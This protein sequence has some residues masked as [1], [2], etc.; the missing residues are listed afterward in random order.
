MAAARPRR[1]IF[2]ALVSHALACTSASTMRLG[3]MPRHATDEARHAADEARRMATVE[4]KRAA[5]EARRAADEARRMATVEAKRAAD[6]ARRITRS[7]QVTTQTTLLQLQT[8]HVSSVHWWELQAREF[9]AGVDSQLHH[10]WGTL[11]DR[12]T[13]PLPAARRLMQRVRSKAT[14]SLT[15]ASLLA[16]E[17]FGQL[18]SFITTELE[19]RLRPR[20]LPSRFPL[21][22]FVVRPIRRALA[23]RRASNLV[24][25]DDV[26]DLSGT[27]RLEERIRM[28]DFLKEMGFSALQRAVVLKAGQVQVIAMRG[29]EL[30]VLTRDVRGT[31]ELVSAPLPP[32]LAAAAAAAAGRLAPPSTVHS[33]GA[34]LRRVVSAVGGAARACLCALGCPMCP[35]RAPPLPNLCRAHCRCCRSATPTAS[36]TR[37]A[38]ATCRSAAPPSSRAATS[39]SPSARRAAATPSPSAAAPCSPTGG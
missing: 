18:P 14:R 10:A 7:I 6:E 27:W 26:A 11:H 31:S 17:P 5:D 15:S 21:Q 12:A 19:R 36:S 25:S 9:A 1:L 29:A 16:R 34:E 39:S 37:T 4:A 24:Q 35:P 32:P 28:D 8:R 13:E 2:A 22:E 23:W 20:R 30:K 33:P 38:T 3:A